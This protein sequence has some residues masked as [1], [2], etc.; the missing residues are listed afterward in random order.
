F[1]DGVYQGMSAGI[2]LDL[3]DISDIQILRGPQATLFGRNTT[4]GAILINTRRPGNELAIRGR[5]RV[6]SGLE[7]EGGL[8]VEGPLGE[9][10]R[11]KLSF[12]YDN[13]SGWFTNRFDGQDFGE[14]RTGILR[15]TLAWNWGPLD[16]TLFYEH[17]WVDG[18]GAAAQNPAYF[19][20]FTID[21][22]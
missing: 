16:S 10:L 4:G 20:G 8:S 7:E 15:P 14:R 12:S 19:Q 11:A 9:T 1:I 18:Q 17:G 22:N 3:F 13:D 5:L 21:I 2:V 6:E